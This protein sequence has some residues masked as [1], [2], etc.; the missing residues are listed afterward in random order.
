LDRGLELLDFRSRGYYFDLSQANHG[1]RRGRM[2]DRCQP[3]DATP[4]M[5][6]VKDYAWKEVGPHR[7]EAKNCP[8]GQGMSHWKEFLQTLAQS[9]FHG[10]ITVHEEYSVP[11]VSDNQGI[12]LSRAKA[13][14]VMAAAQRDL[15]YLKSLL[16]EAYEGA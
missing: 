10:P 3:R 11:G 15:D 7:W 8:L 6:A 14:E 12:A 1:R 16:H 2:E 4:E 5:V 9:K 13:P